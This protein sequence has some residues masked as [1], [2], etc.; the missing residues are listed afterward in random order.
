MAGAGKWS[1]AEGGF[2]CLKGAQLRV[3]S[4]STFYIE[5]LTRSLVHTGVQAEGVTPITKI[6]GIGRRN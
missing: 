6:I 5:V 2:T 4:E 3:S 1:N